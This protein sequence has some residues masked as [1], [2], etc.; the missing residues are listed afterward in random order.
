M[1]MTVQETREAILTMLGAA[2]GLETK[3]YGPHPFTL[4]EYMPPGNYANAESVERGA[5]GDKFNWVAYSCYG[6][7]NYV[8]SQDLKAQL[9][10]AFGDNELCQDVHATIHR[11]ED[12]MAHSVEYCFHT[13]GVEHSESPDGP[14]FCLLC[15]WTTQHLKCN[16][17]PDDHP[18]EN[19]HY[20]CANCGVNTGITT[21][22]FRKITFNM[23]IKSEAF[24]TSS[25]NIVSAVGPDVNNAVGEI[26]ISY[27]LVENNLR[28]MMAKVPGHKSRSNLSE[29]I[30]RLRKHKA[31][32]VVSASAKSTDG[33]RAMD[34][35]I[36]AIVS[37]YDKIRD[38]RNTLA[39]GQL[40]QVGLVTFS[41]GG[42]DVGREKD[43]GSRLQ[44]EHAGETIEL[45]EDGIQPLLDNVRELQ[46]HVG[47]LG[48][49]LELLASR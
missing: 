49:I 18:S 21:P 17:G 19:C 22:C 28:A 13:F 47:H 30:E 16:A 4:D 7:D 26:L 8:N 44:I 12:G 34:E 10:R 6:R 23:E 5:E 35:C 42:D 2:N 20:L 39:H 33:G 46:A 41:I 37:V 1:A 24:L 40:V 36:D 29:D 3:P 45:T 32:I 14:D 27:A 38:K 11:D 9:E 48:Q 31:S 15:G 25:P 43:Q